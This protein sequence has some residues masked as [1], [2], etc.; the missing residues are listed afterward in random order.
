MFSS[1]EI[2]LAYEEFMKLHP[3]TFIHPD[4]HTIFTEYIDNVKAGKQ[5]QTR[6]FDIRKDGTTYHIEVHGIPFEYKEGVS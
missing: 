1:A 2:Y 4:S 6:A 5:Y 3:T